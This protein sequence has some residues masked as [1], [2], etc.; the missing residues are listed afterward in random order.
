MAKNLETPSF[1]QAADEKAHRE[2]DQYIHRDETKRVPVHQHGHRHSHNRSLRDRQNEGMRV[3]R[4][5]TV[6]PAVSEIVNTIAVAVVQQLNVNTAANTTGTSSRTT[7]SIGHLTTA[8]FP[9]SFASSSDV[10]DSEMNASTIATPSDEES[11]I[12]TDSSAELSVRTSIAIATSDTTDT[13]LFNSTESTP[14]IVETSIESA[15]PQAQ[16]STSELPVPQPSETAEA[17]AAPAFTTIVPGQNG[18]ALSTFFQF[19]THDSI[20]INH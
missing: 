10:A 9:A 8:D 11:A 12:V 5:V 2:Q 15:I 16:S 7:N 13:M 18:T 17:P 3:K 20:E 4:E 14:S 19:Y 1:T 6:V